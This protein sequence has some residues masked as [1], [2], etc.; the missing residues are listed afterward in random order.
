MLLQSA[1]RLQKRVVNLERNLTVIEEAKTEAVD[2]SFYKFMLRQRLLRLLWGGNMFALALLIQ[3]L[4][5]ST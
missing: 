1:E 3:S 4:V 5:Q 2:V